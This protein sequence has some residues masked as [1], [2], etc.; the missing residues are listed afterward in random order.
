MW[1]FSVVVLH[2]VDEERCRNRLWR[3]YFDGS[4][5]NLGV[6]LG[7][8]GNKVVAGNDGNGGRAVIECA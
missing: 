2:V 8:A 7:V 1:I 4:T 3:E 5:R 6:I